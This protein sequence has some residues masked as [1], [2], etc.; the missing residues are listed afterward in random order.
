[1]VRNYLRVALRNLLKYKA[2]S[3][4]NI[5]GLSVGVA[6][7]IA[8]M[9]FVRDELSFD[10]YNKHADR[11]YR[12]W[13]SA[14]FYGRDI[15]S[16]QSPPPMGP[17]VHHDF[18]EV[19]AYARLHYEGSSKIE[20]RELTFVEQNF[21]WGDSTLFDVFT[22][23]FV[24]GDPKTA[25]AQPNTVVIT[26][27]TARKYF[28]DENPLGRIL[29]RDKEAD[30]MVTG[31]IRDVPRN[32][33]F[34][35]DFIASLTTIT[36]SRDP[37]WLGN[38]FYTYFLLKKGTDPRLFERRI[39]EELLAHAGPQ[40]KALTGVSIEQFL[41]AG[42]RVGYLLQPL[43]SIHLNS[44]LDYEL[45]QNG[46]VS[47]VYI[48]SAIAIAILLIACINFI[49]LATA[50]SEKR[51]KEVGIR[52]TLG[53]PRSHLVGQ[54]LAESVMMSSAA[55][56]LAV[57]IVELLLPLFNNIADKKLSLGIF[58]DPL[59]IPI[60]IG[61][62]IVVGLIA[63]SYPAFYLSSFRAA[64]VLKSETRKGGRRA[65]LRDGLVVFQFAISIILFVGTFVIYAQLKFIQTKDL[66]FDKEES[67]VIY[68]TDDLSDRLQ[69]F[70]H[71]LMADRDITSITNSD[72]IPGNQWSESGFWLEGT[73]A[74][75]MLFLQ[76]MCCDF[77]FAKTYK[78]E[79][80]QGR[81]FSKEHPSDSNAVVVNEEVMKAFGV[82]NIVGRRLVLPGRNVAD[83][84]RPEVI[85]VAKDFNY[86]SLH[87]PIRPLVI[88]PLRETRAAPFVTVRLAPGNH[89]GTV[90]FIEKVWK[91]YAG[92]EEFEFNFLDESLQKLY[93][94]DQRTN[95]IAGTFSVLAIFIACLGLL[96]LAAFITELRTK[97]IGVR[98]VLGASVPELV[99]LLCSEFAKW[100][101]IANLVAWPAAYYMM[102][103]WLQKFAYRTDLSIWIF[104]LS[105]AMA[106]LIALL[107]VS[108]H[109]IKAAMANP[110]EALRY[111]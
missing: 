20:C 105:G 86:R 31:V 95:K 28:G 66:G 70:E 16:A 26:E 51:A 104:I 45:E 59:S 63:G 48:F 50:R 13:F 101:L 109:A 77:D 100:V 81:F 49:N 12:P 82:K 22:L 29:K 39:N 36:E 37:N 56:I 38:N 88:G 47:T 90:A 34:R 17:T 99:A 18:P 102:I 69:S 103:N 24:K 25:L 9:L 89:L 2:Y 10:T 53:S 106:L 57:G 72:A 3:I 96:G 65:F 92:K 73:G 61:V 110:V 64:D 55:V 41:S 8:I 76:T 1:M 94:A 33:H 68:R 71:E 19:I 87:E 11:I 40:L 32:S 54:F 97:E 4:I 52:K 78:L 108:S 79:M 58:T 46:S 83:E 23:P 98:K 85:G 75:K 7:C 42:N 93:A 74:E 67:V 62:G 60:L 111:E 21:Y 91:K 35:P 30:Y 6:C 84:K 44:H 15:K 43:T 5:I 107:T 27:S 80:V 14:T